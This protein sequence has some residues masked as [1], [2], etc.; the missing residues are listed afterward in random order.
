MF[1]PCPL[2]SVAPS[3]LANATYDSSKAYAAFFLTQAYR[4]EGSGYQ[5]ESFITAACETTAR[6]RTRP[7]VL[8]DVGAAPYGE[9]GGDMAH[10]LTF[11]RACPNVTRI[12]AYEPQAEPFQRLSRRVAAELSAS[13]SRS[14][15]IVELR[16]VPLSDMSREVTLRHQPGAGEN[17]GSIEPALLAS[18]NAS[19]ALRGHALL[20]PR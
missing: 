9:R 20:D 11:L 16:N 10:T 18:M 2:S 8:V 1:S 6:S 4:F 5:V 19:S 17:T 15:S 7:T 13:Q 12:L 14:T 3:S